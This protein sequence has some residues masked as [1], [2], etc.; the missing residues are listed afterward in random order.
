MLKLLNFFGLY[1][2]KQLR[3]ARDAYVELRTT[4]LQ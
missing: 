1:T 3:K 4:S 2:T